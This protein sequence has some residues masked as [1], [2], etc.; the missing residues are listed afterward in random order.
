MT[1]TEEFEFRRRAE[2]ERGFDSTPGGAAMGNPNI[3]NQGARGLTPDVRSAANALATIGGAGA[4]GAGL[5]AVA[6]E[7]LTT[8]AAAASGLP[9]PFSGLRAPLTFM[10]GATRAAGR[11]TGAIGGAISGVASETAGQ[12]AEASGAGPITAE[13]ARLVG[14][15]VGV[16]TANAA[17]W[18]LQKYVTKPALSL[19]MHIKKVFA[20]EL[21]AKLDGDPQTLTARDRTFIDEVTAEIRG[22]AR[23]DESLE[24]VGSIMGEE[25]R[26]LLSSSDQQMAGALRQAGSAGGPSRNW[27]A[28]PNRELADIGG[29]LQ[30]TIVK[31]NAAA[32]KARDAQYKTTQTSRDTIVSQREGA[33]QF[34]NSLPEYRAVVREVESQLDNSV[35]MR[36]SPSVQAIYR[37]ILNDLKGQ[38]GTPVSFQALDDV[39]RKLGESF[40]GKPDEGYGAIEGNAAKDL[41]QKIS[42]IQKK[43]AGEPQSKLLD[44]YA[45]ATKGLEVFSS[46]AGKKVTALD[47]YREGQYPDPSTIPSSFFKTKA[48]V[49]ALQELTGNKSQVSAAAL[50]FANRELA[51]KD[52]SA[53][54][55]WLTKNAEWLTEVGSA[56]SL[57]EKYVK[58]LEDSERS[59]KNA[60]EFVNQAVADN[61]MLTR[62]ALPAQRAIDLIKSGD[63]ELWSKIAPVIERSPQAKMQMVTAARQVVADMA[64]S[65]TAVDFFSRNLRPFLMQSQIATKAEM[66]AIAKRLADIQTMNIPEPQRLGMAKRSILNSFGG[67]TSSGASRGM[68]GGYGLLVDLIPQ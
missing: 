4:I 37:N 18:V 53:A 6:P 59:M 30:E 52:S 27:V 22:G 26:R 63:T 9:P 19:G 56:R 67:Y 36:R 15:G 14:G 39:R 31:R 8:G 61:N 55:S 21:L 43:F 49:Q 42:S 54:R 57:V 24:A 65:N 1:E 16:E 62:K 64:E 23:S 68:T 20:K 32:L 11:P 48:S 13:A 25:G 17:K 40:R 50:E 60:Q 58:R 29:E 45:E 66:D 44:D 51:G 12:V 10:A 41:Y 35:S 7:L 34:V 38:N 28:A 47:Q 2:A 5:G 46:R 33:G 3:R